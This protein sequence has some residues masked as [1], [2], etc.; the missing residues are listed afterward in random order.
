VASKQDLL[1][2][3]M[4]DSMVGLLTAQRAAIAA[5]GDP[6]ALIRRIVEAHIRFHAANREQAFVGN[7]EINNLEPANRTRVLRLRRQYER[8]LRDVIKHGVDSGH[9]RVR[10]AQLAAF[11]ILDM[12]IGLAAW[13]RADGPHSVDEVAYAY[14]D[15]AILIV[16]NMNDGSNRGSRASRGDRRSSPSDREQRW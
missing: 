9:F 7:R 8:G 5:G 12:G 13:F 11:A 15:Y 2:T 4:T 6:V 16:L 14:A 3:I 10:S 1:A